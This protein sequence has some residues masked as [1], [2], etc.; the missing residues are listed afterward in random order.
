MSSSYSSLD[1]VFSHW[2]HFV[3]CRFIYVYV[4]LCA[5]FHTV[6]L[7]AWWGGPDRIEAWSF[8]PIFLQCFDT[9]GWVIWPVKPVPDM[10]YNVFGGTLNLTQLQLLFQNSYIWMQARA[11]HEPYNQHLYANLWKLFTV[12]GTHHSEP[13]VYKRTR[14]NKSTSSNLLWPVFR[15]GISVGFHVFC[16]FSVKLFF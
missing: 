10:T 6:L 1:W 16:V 7:W 8:G 14:E 2:A 11:D 9:V 13:A 12:S 5:F 3:V 15:V 4:C